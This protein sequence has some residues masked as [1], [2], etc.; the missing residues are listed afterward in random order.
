M[1]DERL[2]RQLENRRKSGRAAYDTARALYLHLC[3]GLEHK[4]LHLLRRD[5]PR[6]ETD[7]LFRHR[8]MAEGGPG[9]PPGDVL[10]AALRKLAEAD[11]V[12]RVRNRKTGEVFL[13][14]TEPLD[15][16]RYRRDLNRLI[17]DE[18]FGIV[19]PWVA[20]GGVATEGDEAEWREGLD[21]LDETARRDLAPGRFH[22]AET[23]ERPLYAADQV[24][25]ESAAAEM[26]SVA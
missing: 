22:G 19:N 2:R 20:S 7:F 24:A 6:P 21:G 17:R 14:A 12:R 15:E 5:G 26:E 8:A 13:T 16:S 3:P 9:G 11:K 23:A 25:D 1:Q 18:R 10:R 4:L